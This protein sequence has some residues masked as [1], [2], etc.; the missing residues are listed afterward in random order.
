MP[1]HFI[2]IDEGVWGKFYSTHHL[3]F[4]GRNTME[5]H[6]RADVE[7]IQ[8]QLKDRE[9]QASFS[10]DCKGQY[11]HEDAEMFDSNGTGYPGWDGIEIES[12]SVDGWLF[13]D[14]DGN[15]ISLTDEEKDTAKRQM[16]ESVMDDDSAVVWEF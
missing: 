13:F 2:N 12:V 4:Q 9:I 1:T 16:V 8:I 5:I 7:S 10:A 3:F 14:N 15:E 11:T 6:G